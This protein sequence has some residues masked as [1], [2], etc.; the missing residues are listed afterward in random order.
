[1]HLS[2]LASAI[3]ATLCTLSIFACAPLEPNKVKLGDQLRSQIGILGYWNFDETIRGTAPG[4]K[5]FTDLSGGGHHGTASPG[6]SIGSYGV[7]NSAVSSSGNGSISI[8]VDL[9]AVKTV[10]LSLWVNSRISSPNAQ[11]VL[12]E[13]TP[14]SGAGNGFLAS[15]DDSFGSPVHA[16]LLWSHSPSGFFAQSTTNLNPGW[17]NVVSIFDRSNASQNSITLYLDGT[18]VSTTSYGALNNNS[19][20]PFA[21]STLYL[22]CR[23]GST[24]CLK[25]DLDEL[26]MWDRAVTPEEIQSLLSF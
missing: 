3:L 10:T 8:P 4:A 22:L 9:S 26:V 6:L 24:S 23:A 5:D 15:L 13:Y 17:H 18:K 12:F 2:W 21:N 25:A 20:G 19:A 14:D 7:K 16:F 1:M 11:N